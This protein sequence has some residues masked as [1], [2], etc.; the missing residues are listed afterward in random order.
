MRLT[1][2]EYG[3]GERRRALSGHLASLGAAGARAHR[4]TDGP[5]LAL[6]GDPPRRPVLLGNAEVRV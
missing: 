6:P 5:L 4:L 2:L 1:D 3:G